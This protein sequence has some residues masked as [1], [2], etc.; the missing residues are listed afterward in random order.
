MFKR[1]E[2]WLERF[3]FADSR[4]IRCGGVIE[5]S[6]NSGGTCENVQI[7]SSIMIQSELDVCF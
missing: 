1:H 2:Y 6:K 4:R 5:G 7:H 3:I